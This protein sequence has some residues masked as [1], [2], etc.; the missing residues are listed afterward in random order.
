GRVERLEVLEVADEHV[1]AHR[2]ELRAF[3][4]AANERAHFGFRAL[5]RLNHARRNIA[6]GARD[7]DGLHDRSPL[8][9]AGIAR[10]EGSMQAI[11]AQ[12]YLRAMAGE[13][14]M[15]Q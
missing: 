12:Q 10:M 15:L 2:L 7:D 14:A 11:F 5:E 1:D 9:R 13:K 8:L 3:V 4:L 6:V